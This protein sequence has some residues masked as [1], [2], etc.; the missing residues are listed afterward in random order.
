MDKERYMHKMCVSEELLDMKIEDTDL[1][2]RI[3]HTLQY[4]GNI[5]TVRELIDMTE[6]ELLDLR[7]FRERQL[8]T[9]KRWLADNGLFLGG[10]HRTWRLQ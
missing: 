5:Q 2:F 6:E 4:Y 8:E 9:T 3:R 7:N 10:R 1:P